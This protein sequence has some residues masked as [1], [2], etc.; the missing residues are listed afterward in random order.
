MISRPVAV[1]CR[2]N[3]PVDVATHQVEKFPRHHCDFTGVD[4]VRAEDGAAPA[5]RT[6]IEVVKP[7]LQN[8]LRQFP[9]SSKSPE[10]P[11]G[12]G[13]VSSINGSQKLSPK[14]R[15]ILGISRADKGVALVRTGTTSHTDIEEEFKRAVST[16]AIFHPFQDDLFPILW[17]F[18]IF[19]RGLPFSL[20]REFKIFLVFQ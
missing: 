9:R 12:E 15:H 2:L 19:F 8:I 16:Q 3:D 14:D 18:P 4:A 13:E 5:L 6:L 10:D 17:Q 20:I 1:R 7:F 11:S